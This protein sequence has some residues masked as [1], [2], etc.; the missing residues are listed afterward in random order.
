MLWIYRP[1]LFELGESNCLC[2]PALTANKGHR[3]VTRFFDALP[4]DSARLLISLCYPWP[5]RD[6]SAVSSANIMTE[7]RVRHGRSTISLIT[8][9][10]VPQLLTVILSSSTDRLGL[11]ALP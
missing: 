8:R 3:H 4:N 6:I 1:R 11:R 2:L 10:S 7:V 9:I 5:S